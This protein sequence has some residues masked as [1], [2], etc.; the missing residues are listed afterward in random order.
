MELY[1]SDTGWVREA[2]TGENK[3]KVKCAKNSFS[4]DMTVM[5]Q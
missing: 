2:E 3:V 4:L 5:V 1:N